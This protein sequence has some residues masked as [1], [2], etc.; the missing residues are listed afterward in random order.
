[1]GTHAGVGNALCCM[2]GWNC[3]SGGLI[4]SFLPPP[5]TSANVHL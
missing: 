5:I 3:R 4:P 2:V 1:M